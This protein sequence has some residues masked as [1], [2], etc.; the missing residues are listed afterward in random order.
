MNMKTLAYLIGLLIL[1]VALGSL[2][3]VHPGS[4]IEG[5]ATIPAVEE[6]LGGASLTDA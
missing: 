1:V 2:L 3:F 5:F 6:D 4:A